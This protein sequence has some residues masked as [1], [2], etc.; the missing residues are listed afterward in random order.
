MY[1]INSL[2]NAE[3]KILADYSNG[4]PKKYL[5]FYPGGRLQEMSASTFQKLENITPF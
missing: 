2:I 1:Q 4:T 3:N 5:I